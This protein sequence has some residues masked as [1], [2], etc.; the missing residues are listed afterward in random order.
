MKCSH[1]NGPPER[2]S[3]CQGFVARKVVRREDGTTTVDGQTMSYEVRTT[4]Y[5]T[6][7]GVPAKPRCTYCRK[8][9]HVEANCRDKFNSEALAAAH[10]G[11][12]S[13]QPNSDTHGRVKAK[14]AG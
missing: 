8:V 3:Q 6:L 7:V 2:C 12:T 10:L 4:G 9:G 14:K 11:Q 13:V 5:G 1:G